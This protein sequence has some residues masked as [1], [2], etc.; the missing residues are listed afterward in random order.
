MV[1]VE[2]VEVQ[3]E[4]KADGGSSSH[5]SLLSIF[6]TCSGQVRLYALTPSVDL[7]PVLSIIGERERANLVVRSSGIF[8]LYISFMPPYV[9]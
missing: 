2:R 8:C 5:F 4:V 1:E 9:V 7:C 3:L 6:D